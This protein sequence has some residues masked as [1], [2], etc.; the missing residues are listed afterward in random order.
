MN[1]RA[2]TITPGQCGAAPG[3][4]VS[5]DGD[6][7]T[8]CASC[9]GDNSGCRHCVCFDQYHNDRPGSTGDNSGSFD[10]T[11]MLT[12]QNGINPKTHSFVLVKR[13]PAIRHESP[14][15]VLSPRSFLNISC[16]YIHID[17]YTSIYIHRYIY[18]SI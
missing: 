2:G 16:I 1:D 11:N 15:P 8:D 6:Q 12:I 3:I 18:I 14:N 9:C 13:A 7:Y 5:S 4:F 17:I 10:G